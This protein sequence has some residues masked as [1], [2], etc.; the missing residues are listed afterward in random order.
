MSTPLMTPMCSIEEWGERSSKFFWAGNNSTS[1]G[2]DK[3]GI[4]VE[5]KEVNVFWCETTQGRLWS[6]LAVQWRT[7]RQW[8]IDLCFRCRCPSDYAIFSP[9]DGHC[10]CDC[11]SDGGRDNCWRLKRGL[12]SFFLR[13]RGYDYY[14]YYHYYF[15]LLTTTKATMGLSG[16]LIR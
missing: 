2:N 8:L 6:I 5:C 4:K 12:D 1:V 9:V 7:I 13:D 3:R 11:L 10:V 15:L 16:P 14:Y